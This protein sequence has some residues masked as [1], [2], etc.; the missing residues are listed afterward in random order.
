MA[1]RQRVE[2]LAGIM[3]MFAYLNN[4][5]K[6]CPPIVS[7]AGQIVPD[8]GPKTEAVRSYNEALVATI[9]AM[10]KPEATHYL[11]HAASIPG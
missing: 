9:E 8:A 5:Q 3:A 6:P 2:R 4:E 7:T 1:T 11:G 10:A